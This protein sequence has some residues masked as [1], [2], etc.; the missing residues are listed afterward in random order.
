MSNDLNTLAITT[1]TR[2]VEVGSQ[3]YAYRRFGGGE[4]LPLLCLQ[5]FTGNLDNW[6]P[7]VTS[8]LAEH[9]EVILFD[10]AGIGRSSGEVPKTVGAMADHVLAFLDALDLKSV[11]IL[12]YSLGGMVAMDMVKKRPSVARKLVLVGTA[13]RGGEDI[14]HLNKPS[15]AVHFADPTLKGYDILQ[16]IFFTESERSQSAALAFTKRLTLRQADREPVSGPEVA[17]AQL[18]AF[19]DWE[20]FT[21]ERFADLRAISQP[22][23]VINGV[24]EDMISVK[25]SYAMVENLPNATLLVYPDAGHGSLF[26]YPVSFT[27]HVHDF[28][29]NMDSTGVF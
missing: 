27:K 3:R 24:K 25:N 23:L 6:D 20:T 13:P 4:H 19:R 7:L 28:L 8:A 10:N 22:A 9:R 29:R 1:P 16:K 14:M 21:G 15:L 17:A 11:D 5:H 18:A 26:Q 12:G 2:F